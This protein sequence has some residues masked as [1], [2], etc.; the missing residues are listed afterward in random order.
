MSGFSA[1]VS[2]AISQIKTMEISHAR[3]PISLVD[4]LNPSS[5][6]PV[7]HSLRASLDV[8]SILALTSTCK[9]LHA[10]RHY[11]WDIN[12][13]LRPFVDDPAEFRS[14]LGAADGLISGSF[15]L[16]FF[17]G[18]FWEESDLDVFIRNDGRERAFAAYLT[19]REGYECVNPVGSEVDPLEYKMKGDFKVLT[20]LRPSSANNTSHRPK[21]QII[22][23]KDLPIFRIVQ[24]FYTTCVVNVISWNKAYAIYA[25]P[26]FANHKTYLLRGADDII[27]ALLRKYSDRGWQSHDVLWPEEA[28]S[29][30]N[31]FRTP[32]RVGDEFTWTLPLS[33]TGVRTP[34]TPD[35]VL[36]YAQFGFSHSNDKTNFDTQTFSFQTSY[37]V[38]I[39]PFRAN[40]LR[41]EY[42]FTPS[43]SRWCFYLGER[44]DRLTYL[45]LRKMRPEERPQEFEQSIARDGEPQTRFL[46][47][48][49]FEKP[50]WWTYYDAEIPK[51][52]E[53]FEEDH[54][55]K[56]AGSVWA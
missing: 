25:R 1:N 18:V 35:S 54:G 52:Y 40:V 24:S 39:L 8:R 7:F 27:G 19:H 23:T 32:R 9:H 10:L 48:W 34:K 4:L 21:I 30:L 5:M 28:R 6:Y 53:Q 14:Q 3:Q 44:V 43:D 49:K 36:E 42:T 37:H 16:Q 31:P 51:W 29:P 22:V 38:E 50:A 20:Y 11:L 17:E 46:Y 45:E 13:S 55:R 56:K 12:R 47:T 15:V 33:T 41:Y 26:T 2:P